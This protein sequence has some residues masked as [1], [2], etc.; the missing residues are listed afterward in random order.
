MG[1]SPPA[2]KKEDMLEATKKPQIMTTLGLVPAAGA[3]A[4]AAA[5]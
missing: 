1:P 4:A 3:A 5:S 2:T